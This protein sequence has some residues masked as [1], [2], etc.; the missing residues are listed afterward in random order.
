MQGP[1]TRKRGDR[2]GD[3]V[4]HSHRPAPC[5]AFASRSPPTCRDCSVRIRSLSWR[6][7]RS[8]PAFHG[9][10]PVAVTSHPGGIATKRLIGLLV[11]LLVSSVA[12]T[13]AHA[14]TFLNATLVCDSDGNGTVGSPTDAKGKVV[15][16]SNGTFKVTLSGL[17]A[18]TSAQCQI[19]CAGS[20]TSGD[21]FPCGTANAA[22]RLSFTLKE[23]IDPAALCQGPLV[24]MVV[25][26]ASTF[27]SCQTGSGT[28]T[29]TQ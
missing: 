14:A 16:M 4:E 15:I 17:S 1:K 27:A 11:A 9:W 23:A 13:D 24:L 5:V 25:S 22:G 10:P 12:W 8:G 18:G 19:F 3:V 26:T 29:Q 20:G 7:Q 28:G 2:T 6:S 21:L